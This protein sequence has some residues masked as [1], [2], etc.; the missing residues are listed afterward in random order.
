[1]NKTL[2]ALILT[3]F[4]C[5]I[6]SGCG[7]LPILQRTPLPLETATPKLSLNQVTDIPTLPPV[8]ATPT[9]SL[10]DSVR[11]RDPGDIFNQVTAEVLPENPFQPV[12]I[13]GT[14]S[15]FELQTDAWGQVLAT[16]GFTLS[17]HSGTD[18]SV[19]CDD[20]CFKTDARKNL[21]SDE[22]LVEGSEVIVFGACGEDVT[23]INAD[24]VAIHVLREDPVP[25]EA[26]VSALPFDLNYSEYELED[27]PK[28]N[29]ISIR[30]ADATSTPIPTPTA[31]G[32]GD[33]SGTDSYDPY[34]YGY[35][36][37]YYGYYRPTSTPNRPQ[38]TPTPEDSTP[39]PTP[40]ISLDEH[41]TERLNHSLELRSNYS[42]GAYGEKYSSYIEYSQ[43]L[44]RDPSYPTRA[45]M[46]VDSNGYDFVHY[47]FPYVNNPMFTNWGIVCFAGDWYLPVRLTVDINPDPNITD[48]VFSDRTFRSNSNYDK[49]RG[50][51]RSFGY[52]IID[53][54]LFYFYQ[55]EQGYGISLSGQ[56]FDLG[57]DDIPF[58][59][60]S[61]FSEINPFYADDLITFFG[62]RGSKWYYVELSSQE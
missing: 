23:Q 36:Y 12:I 22:K 27:F 1:M 32:A 54:K 20:F 18:F 44:N 45:C 16:G 9:L 48:L 17:H 14:V 7:M 39:E 26:E 61:D 62:H 19:S 24:L 6:L 21:V 51:L 15:G 34:G 4:L 37:D 38:R 60:V 29:P 11:Y 25:H 35:G 3:L 55:T 46:N 58:G 10:Q 30:A 5:F 13:F 33:L 53:R 28:L 56:D 52:S 41:L 47:W 8:T 40:T 49:A 42:W 57:F 43:D 59:Y 2:K 50:Y 31:E